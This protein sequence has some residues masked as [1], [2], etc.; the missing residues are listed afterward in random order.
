MS[1][2]LH[3]NVAEESTVLVDTAVHTVQEKAITCP[4]DTK[5]AIKIINRLNKLANIHSIKQR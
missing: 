1:F 5:L 4:A 3:G 2:A